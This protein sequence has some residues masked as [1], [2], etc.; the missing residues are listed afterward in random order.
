MPRARRKA[1][2]GLQWRRNLRNVPACQAAAAAAAQ[3]AQQPTAAQAP[4]PP[5]PPPQPRQ[6][7]G[8]AT[9][10]AARVARAAARAPPPGRRPLLPAGQGEK[11]IDNA[12][13]RNRGRYKVKRIMAAPKNVDVKHRGRTVR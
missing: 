13:I 1:Q 3:A 5:I 11:N 4:P 2:R 10:A 7:R 9:R 8:R 12:F 6:R